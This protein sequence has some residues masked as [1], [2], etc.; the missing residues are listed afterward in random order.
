MIFSTFE[1]AFSTLLP[2]YLDGSPSRS[3]TASLAPVEAPEGTLARKVPDRSQPDTCDNVFSCLTLID[4]HVD[5]NRR[6]TS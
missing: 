1:A 4:G 3:S 5:L 2:P 6:V